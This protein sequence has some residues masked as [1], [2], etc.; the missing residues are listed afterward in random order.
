MVI[1]L[2]KCAKFA[3]LELG[4]KKG[5]PSP[6]W[7]STYSGVKRNPKRRFGLNPKMLSS[8]RKI[9]TTP[10]AAIPVAKVIK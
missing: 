4:F 2:R 7:K 3:L 6:L 9:I 1:L 8:A 5:T 10:L